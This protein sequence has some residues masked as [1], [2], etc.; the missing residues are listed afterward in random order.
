M[1][2]AAASR[3]TWSALILV[4]VLAPVACRP[5]RGP[6]TAQLRDREESEAFENRR[7]YHRLTPDIL[8]GIPDSKLEQ[9]VIDFIDLKVAGRASQ[10]QAILRALGPGFRAIDATWGVEIE[11]NGGGFRQYFRNTRGQYAADA[12]QGFMIIGQRD[13]ARLME[14]AIAVAIE[15]Q[16]FGDPGAQAR[17][18][19]PERSSNPYKRLDERFAVLSG[20][21]GARRVALIR[22]RPDLFTAE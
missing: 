13:L 10:K 6:D 11:V 21:V 20:D 19:A 14:D 15:Q 5:P 9:V 7:I 12:V 2:A 1:R 16:A 3:F 18:S 17:S 22:A 4:S 8:A